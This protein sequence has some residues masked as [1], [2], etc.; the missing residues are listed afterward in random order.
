MATTVTKKPARIYKDLDLLFKANA[1]SGDI[2]KKFDVNAVKQSMMNLLMI[3]PYERKFHPELGSPLGGILFEH[4]LPG[5]EQTLKLMITQ[6]LENHE[7]RVVLDRVDVIPVYS[8]NLYQVNIQYQIRG[9]DEPQQLSLK[10]TR[11]R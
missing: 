5:T 8:R 11:L 6:I 4:M 3:A 2:G 10:L 7:P 1:F 9:V